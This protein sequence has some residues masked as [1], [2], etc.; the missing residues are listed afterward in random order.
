MYGSDSCSIG[1]NTFSNQ[2]EGRELPSQEFV[3]ICI[4]QLKTILVVLHSS[5]PTL[6]SV[7]RRMVAYL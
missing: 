1:L 4:H 3:G 7:D 6:Q 5:W 2:L